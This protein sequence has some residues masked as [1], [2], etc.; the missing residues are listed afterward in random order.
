MGKRGPKKLVSDIPPPPAKKSKVPIVPVV[1][2]A[3]LAAV[4]ALLVGTGSGSGG[5][6]RG[7]RPAPSQ[8]TLPADG[9]FTLTVASESA[10][11]E[12][13][14]FKGHFA[15]LNGVQV[16]ALGGAS[17]GQLEV[18]DQLVAIGGEDVATSSLED[19]RAK[20]TERE[21]S[22]V[23]AAAHLPRPLRRW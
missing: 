15:A 11:P 17:S 3:V 16:E 21:P 20:L 12:L 4:A 5:S 1:V 22:P 9:T 18:G 2:A 8:V 6:G 13:S 14:E 7:W 10:L 19:V 23:P